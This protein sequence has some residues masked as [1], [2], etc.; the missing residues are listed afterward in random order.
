[1]EDSLHN[2][3]ANS[4]GSG[5][6]HMFCEIWE[7]IE[8]EACRAVFGSNLI[9]DAGADFDCTAK[10]CRQVFR[11]EDIDAADID[12]HQLG[13]EDTELLQGF[14]QN[15]K[16]MDQSVA[17]HVRREIIQHAK[18]L[19]WAIDHLVFASL[20]WT[21]DVIKT[22][23]GILYAGM[24]HDEIILGEYRGADHA[25]DAKY[26]DPKTGKKKVIKFIHPRAVPSYMAAWVENLNKDIQRAERGLYLNP[27]DFPAKHY[28][29]FINI[30]PFG[31]CNGRTSRIIL[32]CLFMKFSGHLIP[33]G[34][35]EEEK[36]ELLG[37]AARGAK[38]YHEED[39]EVH[40]NEQKGHHEMANF[41]VR[42]ALKPSTRT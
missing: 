24:D 10:L 2:K 5:V 11:G 1:M 17:I 38:K 20:P 25:I 26:V 9:E 18:A 16:Q 39:G 34:E 22:I 12:E 19:S 29:H 8:D 40:L 27:Y 33:L 31:D 35:N 36:E 6:T 3:P 37:I 28:H 30:H 23:H 15:G 42:K 13:P 4:N 32:N 21:E 7:R 14:K 41:M